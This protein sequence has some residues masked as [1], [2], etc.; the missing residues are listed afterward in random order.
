M[1][2]GFV[3]LIFS[4][5]A[6]DPFAVYR[7]CG[8]RLCLLQPFATFKGGGGAV[9]DENAAD[10]DQVHPPHIIRTRVSFFFSVASWGE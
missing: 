6:L 2:H 5:C 3:I 1:V 9:A 4:S 8:A 7:G 10:G